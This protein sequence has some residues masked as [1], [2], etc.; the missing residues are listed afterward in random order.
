MQKGPVHEA[1]KPLCWLIGKWKSI[2]TEGSYPTIQ[3]FTYRDEI[4]FE[5]I[6]QPILNYSSTTWHPEKGNPMHLESGFLRIKPGTNEIAFM[7]SHNFGL[8]TLEEGCVCNN[9]LTCKSTQISRMSFVKDPSV[10]AIE[11]SFKLIEG[12]NLEIELLMETVRTPLTRHLRAVYE[13]V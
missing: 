6:G 3:P 13:K 11:R 10:V 9:E 12:G 4:K 2:K 7:V 8:T 5:S 1:L